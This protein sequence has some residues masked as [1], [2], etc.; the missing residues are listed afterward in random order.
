MKKELLKLWKEAEKEAKNELGKENP[1]PFAGCLKKILIEKIEYDK[2]KY[3]HYKMLVEGNSFDAP[4]VMLI[5]MV[6]TIISIILGLIDAELI[7]CEPLKILCTIAYI[8]ALFY[9]IVLAC[10]ITNYMEHILK[11]KKIGIVL[12]EIYKER[13]EGKEA[14]NERKCE[15]QYRTDNGTTASTVGTTRDTRATIQ[16]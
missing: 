13:F 10:V 12:D 6:G 7:N 4:V 16:K 9:V 2:N 15:K 8:V 1:L 14:N 5:T 3:L 11:Y